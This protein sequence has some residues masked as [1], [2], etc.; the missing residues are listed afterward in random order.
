MNDKLVNIGY[1]DIKSLIYTIRGKQVMLDSD[2]AHLY[3]YE[4]KYVNLAARRNEERF[5]EDFRFQLTEEEFESL[6][7]QFATLDELGRGQHRKYLP[8]VYTEQRNFNVSTIIE[9]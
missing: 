8:Y 1:Q 4:T 7:L 5:P 2:V 9:K 3:K 6:R